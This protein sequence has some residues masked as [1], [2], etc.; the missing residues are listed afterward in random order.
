[1]RTI[2]LLHRCWMKCL[3]NWRWAW[4]T[5][6]KTGDAFWWSKKECFS[7]SARK[8]SF[9]FRHSDKCFLKMQYH[10][11]EHFLYVKVAEISKDVVQF[12]L[13][14]NNIVK[15]HFKIW[16]PLLYDYH[17]RYVFISLKVVSYSAN[18]S[19]AWFTKYKI[20]I[21]SSWFTLDQTR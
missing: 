14:L 18:L 3:I 8:L 2:L 6:Q 4:P 12:S 21:W 19:K 1:M 20:S 7:F 16:P 11:V 9:F 10:T 15:I 5:G 17:E 13:K